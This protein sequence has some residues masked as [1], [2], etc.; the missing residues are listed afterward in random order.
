[1]MLFASNTGD[2]RKG[3]L[4][5]WK[6]RRPNLILELFRFHQ[7]RKKLLLDNTLTGMMVGPPTDRAKLAPVGWHDQ[8]KITGPGKLSPHGPVIES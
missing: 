6:L 2:I 3:S 5:F 8:G 1:M 4:I 7:G